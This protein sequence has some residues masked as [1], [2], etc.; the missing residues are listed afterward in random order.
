MDADLYRK[1]HSGPYVVVYPY[2]RGDAAVGIGDVLERLVTVRDD[3]A[4][5]PHAQIPV[6]TDGVG[7]PAKSTRMRSRRAR[8]SLGRPLA[9]KQWP[10]AIDAEPHCAAKMPLGTL[11]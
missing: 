8:Q 5:G 2:A 9:L 6:I 11:V 1:P 3:L 4:H 10:S 7:E